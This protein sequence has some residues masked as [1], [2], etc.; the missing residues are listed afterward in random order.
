[1][2]LAIVSTAFPRLLF[3]HTVLPI[4]ITNKPFDLSPQF[5]VLFHV[6]PSGDGKL[7]QD[8]FSYPFRVVGQEFV[9][10]QQLLR[11]PLYIIKPIDSH[12]DFCIYKSLLQYGNFFLYLLGFNPCV[13]L[14]WIN[15]NRKA[16]DDQ[17]PA[18][19][20]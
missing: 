8:N 6:R 20:V 16:V 10:C 13:E 17:F 2:W 7:D 5:L 1:M 4:D 19:V 15:A 14:V 3:A 12:H 11:N 9:K 18:F